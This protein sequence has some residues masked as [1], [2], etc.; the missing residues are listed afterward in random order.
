[1]VVFNMSLNNK[2]IAKIILGILL[3]LT[4]VLIGVSIYKMILI[5]HKKE[6]TCIDKRVVQEIPASNYT[7]MLKDVHDNIDSY[8]GKRIRV[9]GFIYRLEDFNKNQF[10]LAREM[11]ISSGFQAVTVGFLCDLNNADKYKDGCWVEIEGHIEK[12]EYH[13]EVPVLKIESIKEVKTPSSEYVY[14]PG[15]KQEKM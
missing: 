4:L 5:N 1:M 9:T 8:I 7:N 10:V 15:N 6:D 11:I 13:G 2:K 12:G 14:P 3:I